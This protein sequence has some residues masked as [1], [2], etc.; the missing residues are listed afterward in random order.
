MDANTSFQ[1]V[2][3]NLAQW[4]SSVSEL[5]VYVAGRY[6]EYASEYERLL[7]Q[8]KTKKRRSDSISSIHSKDEI[9]A[10][11]GQETDV[12]NLPNAPDLVEISPLEAG[13]RFIYAQAN[14][15][16]KPGTS[17]RS[18]A[19]GPSKFRSKQ[20]V[21]V[22]YDSH[23]QSELEKLVKGLGAARNNLR[24]GRNA[25]TAVKGFGL[26]PLS[27]RGEL[28]IKLPANVMSRS[29]PIISKA[30]GDTVSTIATN[31]PTVDAA[32]PKTD[33]E[34]D[35]IQSLCETA[36]HQVLRDGDCKIELQEALRRMDT[37]QSLVESALDLLKTE[38]QKETEENA[39][40]ADNV[41]VSDRSFTHSTLYEKPSIQADHTYSKA[42]SPVAGSLPLHKPVPMM[43]PHLAPAPIATDVIEVD[44][45]DDD[46]DDNNSVDIDLNFAKYRATGPTRVVP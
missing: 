41:S 44:D 26:P 6:D 22:Y 21:V 5:A 18:N 7:S 40:A 38:Q 43:I 36:A 23:V 32:F 3:D 16:R 8:I 10:Q 34:L 30:Q 37:L 2:L 39:H 17:L 27:R 1:H 20:R 33:N 45:D 11:P 13:N 31:P 12:S 4:R 19:S 25:Y 42:V 29:N 24:K 14:K 9:E 28:L 35:A 15:K 46:D